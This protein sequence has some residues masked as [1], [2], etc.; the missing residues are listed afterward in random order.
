MKDDGFKVFLSLSLNVITSF[1]LLDFAIQNVFCIDP[2]RV[3]FRHVS[4]N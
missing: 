3:M 4:I 2:N 1:V